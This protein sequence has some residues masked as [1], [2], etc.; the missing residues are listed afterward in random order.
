M[1][2]DEANN[3]AV[4]GADLN[5]DIVPEESESQYT[6]AYGGRDNDSNNSGSENDWKDNSSKILLN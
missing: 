6:N 2:R 3:A 1:A 5:L 4:N